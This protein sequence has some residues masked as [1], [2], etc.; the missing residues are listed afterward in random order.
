MTYTRADVKI[1]KLD[2]EKIHVGD[3][4]ELKHTLKHEDVDLF[5]ALTG[6][7]NP[8]HVDVDFAKQTLFR[9]PV[10]HGMLSASFVSTM[11]GTILPGSGALWTSQTLEFLL[12]AF[13]GDTLTVTAVVI[14][15]SPA[16]RMIVLEIK[17]TNQYSQVLVSGKSTV[18]TLEMGEILNPAVDNNQ[19]KSEIENQRSENA[20]QTSVFKSLSVGASCSVTN[21]GPQSNSRTIL[22]TGASRGI[23]A[24]IATALAE[25][26]YR[27][28]I[29][30]NSDVTAASNLV[31]QLNSRG[32]SVMAIRANV[33][34]ESE[35]FGLQYQV[36]KE[37]GSISDVIHC[38]APT[39]VPT[40]FEDISWEVFHNHIDV[41]LRGA[42]NCAKIFLPKM[43]EAKEGSLLF[44]GSIYAE[45]VP[46]TQQSAYVSAKAALTAFARS[47]AVEYGPKG[48]RSNI[49]APGMTQ[50]DMIANIPDKTK[51]LTK[52]NTPLRKLAEPHEI[53][54]VAVFLLG[55]GGRHITGET[56]RVCGGIS[57]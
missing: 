1:F 4:A 17:I 41:Q 6:D 55:T 8:L 16:T 37:F 26:G 28:V 33:A 38:A 40:S 20:N 9:K 12:P 13:I 47:I 32:F 51:L 44:I 2:F 48:I 50:T 21:T 23:G 57:M 36:E 30:Y 15:K 10:V 43:V 25:A 52:M 54:N 56:I 11:I 7:F 53:A 19:L 31:F 42:F 49:I 46:P 3:K 18:R 34:D 45:G 5:A 39:P 14:Q 24:A 29:N 22:I 35:M 27:V